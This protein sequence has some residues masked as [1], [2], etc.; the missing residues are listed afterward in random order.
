[1]ED[2]GHSLTIR[3]KYMWFPGK[4]VKDIDEKH[5]LQSI[6]CSLELRD[7]SAELL[8]RISRSLWVNIF[9]RS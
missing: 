5:L 9:E 1:M 8:Q 2:T 7:S 6:S 3:Q 4:Q